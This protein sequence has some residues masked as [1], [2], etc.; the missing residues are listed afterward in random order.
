MG[1][2]SAAVR[3]LPTTWTDRLLMVGTV[4][5]A[6]A[7]V[8]T[9][10]VFLWEDRRIEAAPA[11]AASTRAEEAPPPAT[12]EQVDTAT[13]P[14]TTAAV[15]GTTATRPAQAPRFVLTAA[16]G[17]CWLEV[18]RESRSGARLFFGLLPRGR[19]LRLSESRLWV[20]AGA[21]EQLEIFVDGKRVTAQTAGSLTFAVTPTGVTPIRG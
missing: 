12:V 13:A 17:A 8:G 10:A 5:C 9:L 7:L 15:A 14:P 21:L 2:E 19:S 4:A 16:R 6:V 20:R 11:P 3:L 1:I 18:H